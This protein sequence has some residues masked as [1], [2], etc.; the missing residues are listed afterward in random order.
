MRVNDPHSAVHISLQL[1]RFDIA[2]AIA[3]K[4]NILHIIDRELSV[5]LKQ[6]LAAG[7]DQGR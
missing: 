6:L 2:A 4:H 7:D 3:G 1:K 5:Y